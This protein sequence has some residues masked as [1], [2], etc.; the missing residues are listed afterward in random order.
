[1][2]SEFHSRL[3]EKVFLKDM[4]YPDEEEIESDDELYIDEADEVG[5]GREY[6][7]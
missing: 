2:T 6:Q 3:S 7:V 1:M 5:I 4:E